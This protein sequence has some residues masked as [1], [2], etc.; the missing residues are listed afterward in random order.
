MIERHYG[1]LR[2][3]AGFGIASRLDAFEA[4][5]QRAADRAAQ[6]SGPLPGQSNQGGSAAVKRIPLL[7]RSG[8]RGRNRDLR[9]GKPS[10][11][12]RTLAA[13]H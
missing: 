9:L 7:E 8:R 3:G 1:T 10:A 11:G 12:L 5:R 13:V 2:D 6:A 4:E